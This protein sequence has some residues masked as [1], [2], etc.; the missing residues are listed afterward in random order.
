MFTDT[1]INITIGGRK[2][3]GA[4]TGSDKYKVQYVKDLAND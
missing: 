4:A 3:L 1:N 2:H